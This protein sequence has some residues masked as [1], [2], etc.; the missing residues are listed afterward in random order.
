MD[1]R[2]YDIEI[3]RLEDANEVLENQNAKLRRENAILETRLIL[4]QQ[5]AEDGQHKFTS[6]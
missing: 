6:T 5:D 3:Q 4:T 1:A 2:E